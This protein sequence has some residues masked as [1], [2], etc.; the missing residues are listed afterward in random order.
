MTVLLHEAFASVAVLSSLISLYQM[1]QI[2]G[3]PHSVR[4]E[5]RELI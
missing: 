4:K 3:F 2:A 5:A 1:D